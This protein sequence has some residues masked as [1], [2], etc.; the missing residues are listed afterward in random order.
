MI[1]RFDDKVERSREQGS[2]KMAERRAILYR[3]VLPDHVCPHGVRATERLEAEGF[4]VDDRLLRTRAKVD[5]FKDEQKVATTPQVFIDGDP[6]GGADDLED[7]L[8]S[9]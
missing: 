1:W 8:A 5:A 7:W 6:I 3:M 4:T 2:G 9:A